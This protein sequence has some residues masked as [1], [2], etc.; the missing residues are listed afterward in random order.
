MTGQGATAGRVV[1]FKRHLRVE[2]I[3]GEAVYLFSERGV[4]A[5]KGS[6][7]EALAPLLDSTRDLPALLRDVPAGVAAEQV[8]RFI[9]RLDDAGLI[10][11]GPPP[12]TRSAER[13]RAYWEA[14]GTDA[15]AAVASTAAKHVQVIAAGDADPS[16]ALAAL[17]QAGLTAR[18]SSG[19]LTTD[20]PADLSVVLCDDYLSPD[21]ADIDAVHRTMRR[22][23]LLAKLAGAQVWLGPVFDSPEL[24][25]W[26]CLASRLW[27]HRDA[28]AHV[29]A[30]LGRMGPAS[31]PV[32]SLPA[33]DAM[34]AQL[35]TLEVTKWLAGYRYPG[36]RGVLTFDS[37]DLTGRH[38]EF[39]R[40]PQCALCGDP[41]SM[42]TLARRPV[43][44]SSR[45]KSPDNAGGHRS[46]PPQQVLDTYQHLISPVTGVIKEI[47]RHETGP[48]FFNSFRAGHN[49]AVRR[50]CLF[51]PHAAPRAENGGKGVT[52]L[53][54]RVSAMCEALE[55]H[56][57]FFHGDEERVRG[58]YKS[59]GGRAIHPSSCQLFDDR[60]YPGRSAWNATHS[61]FQHVPDPFDDNAVLDWTPVWSLTRERH[62]LLPTAMLYYGAPPE[63]GSVSLYADSNGN[64]A[65]SCLEDAVLQ[66]MLELVE[67]DSVA[68]WWYNRTR[69][70]EVDLAAFGDPWVDE[71]REVYAGLDREVWVL[72]VTADS[73][74][75]VLVA[76]SRRIDGGNE[77]IM[78]GFGAHLDPR[79]ALR[80]A[81][82]EMN[83]LMPVVVDGYTWTEPEPLNWWQNA[84][85]ANQPYLV[86]DPA[87]RARIPSDYG[88][89]PSRDL[90]DD[91]TRVR[92]LIEALGLEVLVLDQTR[93]DIGLPVVKVV[94]PGMRSF[95]ARF[96]PGRLF[97]VPVRLGWQPEPTAYHDLNPTPLFI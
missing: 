82:T 97:D 31:R 48:A 86:A 27:A 49:V 42:R 90:L 16:A 36:Q 66:G 26:H 33:L 20:N 4:T 53:H 67:R 13:T 64:A 79:V 80:R 8:G 15:D 5:L 29:Q 1:G 12:G 78:F 24:G 41:T 34:A 37:L 50:R 14:A 2:V 60:Q 55:R 93:P 3:K 77:D 44:L 85:V 59:L 68:M 88:Y 47:T 56:S 22:P 75:P 87:V 9:A 52:P 11:L 54:G 38:H 40:R 7:A 17:R 76:L 32:A 94:V 10:T 83:Q 23:W 81:L 18:I 28:E 63:A 70:P 95:W 61:P 19:E 25:C 69:R 51:S 35:M 89:T 21:L 96:A 65:G 43:L 58:S 6:D 73:G 74:I 71:L 39:R 84:T 46:M 91:V 72:D 62:R 45:P 57:G 30:S 92:G